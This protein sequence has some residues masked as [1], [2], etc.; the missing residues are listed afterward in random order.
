MAS[1]LMEF[2][3]H[4]DALI[5]MLMIL[6]LF[7]HIL[8][9]LFWHI[10]L[11]ILLL[12]EKGRV[13]NKVKICQNATRGCNTE[14]ATQHALCTIQEWFVGSAS[15]SKDPDVSS[16]CSGAETP[17]RITW[18]SWWQYASW[19]FGQKLRTEDAKIIQDIQDCNTCNS[20]R[21]SLRMTTTRQLGLVIASGFCLLGFP[22]WTSRANHAR[23]EPRCQPG[24]SWSIQRMLG[25]LV[26]D[27]ETWRG[28]KTWSV[29]V[30]IWQ[31]C[32]PKYKMRSATATAV[33]NHT[34]TW[35]A[36]KGFRV[37]GSWGC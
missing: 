6:K 16:S 26:S 10:V 31:Q 9:E 36:H 20:Q 19:A 24:P 21:K 7:W 13:Q 1:S 27:C 4:W 3:S 37:S 5:K 11:Q 23:A 30:P 18:T 35:Q 32:R 33:L 34:S 25:C 8:Y 22:Y 15:L 17:S 28:S 29:E 14:S 2:N 12:G